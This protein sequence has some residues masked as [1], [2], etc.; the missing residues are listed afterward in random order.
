MAPLL[1]TLPPE[2]LIHIIKQIQQPSHLLNLTQG[3][4]QFHHLILPVLYIHL[5][6]KPD[7][8]NNTFA[9][10]NVK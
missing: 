2:I 7:K 8:V 4:H 6:V 1:T 9:K 3:C 5:S 10:L